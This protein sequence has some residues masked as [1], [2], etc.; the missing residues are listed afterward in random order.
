MESGEKKKD[1]DK[2]G[3]EEEKVD[4]Y[5]IEDSEEE[6]DGDGKMEEEGWKKPMIPRWKALEGRVK[7]VEAQCSAGKTEDRSLKKY[8][9]RL[10]ADIKSMQYDIGVMSRDMKGQMAQVWEY[11][12]MMQGRISK[13]KGGSESGW[14]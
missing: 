7:Y 12:G 1:D 8:L 2:G 14:K 4:V 13:L 9:G 3:E 6:E 10:D 11:C 5:K